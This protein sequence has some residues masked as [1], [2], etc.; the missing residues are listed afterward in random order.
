M[1]DATR[2]LDYQ[3][4]R[5]C[6]KKANDSQ[7]RRAS[8]YVGRLLSVF[9]TFCSSSME[10]LLL[11]SHT[12]LRVGLPAAGLLSDIRGLRM[13]EE[14][15]GCVRVRLVSGWRGC[16]HMYIY[17]YITTTAATTTTAAAAAAAAK[18]SSHE[19]FFVLVF[20]A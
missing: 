20:A 9:C 8:I 10:A 13:E 1:M 4:G 5:L 7:T 12:F 14:E 15:R 17:A 6:F 2:L 16:I 19:K 18:T 11:P 3:Q